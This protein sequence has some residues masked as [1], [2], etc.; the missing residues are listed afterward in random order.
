[1]LLLPVGIVGGVGVVVWWGVG[2]GFGGVCVW[3]VVGFGVGV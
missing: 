1:M 2:C 3:C